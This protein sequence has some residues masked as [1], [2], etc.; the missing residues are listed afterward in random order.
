M[1]TKHKT[2]VAGAMLLAMTPFAH[3]Q[4]QTQSF[5]L[6]PGWNAIYLH[7]DATHV[8]ISEFANDTAVEEVWMWKPSV[9]TAQYVVTPDAPT[10]SKSRWLSWKG[11]L[12]DNSSEFSRMP[13]NFAYLVK[14]KKTVA[15]AVDAGGEP[16]GELT[17][18]YADPADPQ[19]TWNIKGKPV[20]P[21]YQWTTT[22]LNFFGVPSVPDSTKSLSDY[23]QLAGYLLQN[24]RFFAYIGGEISSG[25]NP[26]QVYGTRLKAAT[27]GEAYWMDAGAQFNRYF[28]PFSVTLQSS[29]GAHFGDKLSAYRVRLRNMTSDD[30]TVSL[31][32]VV[33]EAVPGGQTAIAGPAP[34]LVRG[35][36]DT[37]TLVYGHAVLADEDQSWT[38]KPDGTIGSEVEVVLG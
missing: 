19:Y 23:F 26:V 12:G 22:G 13:G 27:R 20:A 8:D 9:S 16:T 21:M 7:V 33:S 32:G 4:W 34:V 29:G 14:L 10:D 25:T 31:A 17:Y 11:G 38:L 1:N 3:A 15:Q 5:D 30:L 36:R 24:T 2:W 28:G 35:A 6:V 18:D 37:A